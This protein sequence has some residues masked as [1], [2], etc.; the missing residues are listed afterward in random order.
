MIAYKLVNK[1][2]LRGFLLVLLFLIFPVEKTS[3]FDSSNS[4]IPSYLNSL[5]TKAPCQT[6]LS[7]TEPFSGP[8]DSYA[9]GYFPIFA[10]L[11]NG[12]GLCPGKYH[13]TAQCEGWTLNPIFEDCGGSSCGWW[14][15]LYDAD[16]RLLSGSSYHEGAVVSHGNIAP[17]SDSMVY[18]NQ[19]DWDTNVNKGLWFFGYLEKGG[20]H[21]CT[22][23]M[24]QYQSYNADTVAP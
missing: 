16:S 11:K 24:R 12:G 17:N 20:Y 21:H 22:V 7:D 19:F 2:F 13:A 10:S 4:I 15:L 5:S 14:V 23:Y 6:Q 18:L 3:A 8:Q 9:H 1:I